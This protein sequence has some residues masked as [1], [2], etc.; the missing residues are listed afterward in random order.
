MRN[1][2][3]DKILL[4]MTFFIP[5]LAIGIF[6]LTLQLNPGVQ[7]YTV[8]VLN[9]D[10]PTGLDATTNLSARASMDFL[11]ASADLRQHAGADAVQ[12]FHVVETLD[13]E[14]FTEARGQALCDADRLDAF[15]VLP[16]NFS[17]TIFGATWWYQ[18]LREGN[19]SDLS[20]LERYF[21]V[22]LADYA[23]PEHPDV[24]ADLLEYLRATDFPVNASP[25]FTIYVT[26]DSVASPVIAGILYQVVNNMILVYNN[27]QPVT[28][29]VVYRNAVDRP[30]TIWD[31]TMPYYVVVAALLPMSPMAHMIVREK[32]ARTLQLIDRTRASR[33]TNLLSI[34]FTQFLLGAVQMAIV[35]ACVAVT[36]TYINPRASFGLFYLTLLLLSFVSLG[37]GLIIGVLARNASVSGLVTYAT[38]V[39]LQLLGETFFPVSSAVSRWIPTYYATHAASYILIEGKGLAFLAPWLGMLLVFGVAFTGLAVLLFS[40]KR[41]M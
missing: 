36:G 29:D 21:N 23:T 2:Y 31:T 11:D 5:I 40:V 27:L 41:E 14:P 28:A 7:L 32:N 16:E 17:E 33:W 38:S 34:Q 35:V 1:V 12:Y 25:S 9:R 4:V 3:R 15:V 19:F 8:G 39:T 18:S 24:E 13:G 10:N 30:L 37:L 6:S 22:S 20:A 26:P